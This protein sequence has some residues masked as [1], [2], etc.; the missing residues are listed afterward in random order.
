MR[1]INFASS[2][3]IKE[4]KEILE[5]FTVLIVDD[6]VAIQ[7]VTNI[8]LED[9]TH[10][11]YKLNLI[12]ANSETEAIKIIEN[13]PNIA[14]IILD[15]VMESYDSGFKLVNYIRDIQKNKLVRIII[16]TGQAGSISEKE[17]VVEY[18]INDY[19]DKTKLNSL[20]LFSKVVMAI[21]TYQELLTLHKENDELKQIIKS[22]DVKT[23]E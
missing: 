14:V 4:I 22:S 12:Y 15:V 21:R 13:T 1:Q 20:E 9:F 18:E 5:V 11:D 23:I 17:A 16:R 2:K 3:E 8:I 10:R 19:A 6:D 7:E